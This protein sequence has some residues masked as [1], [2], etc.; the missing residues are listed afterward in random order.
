VPV[1]IEAGPEVIAP[2]EAEAGEEVEGLP[3]HGRDAVDDR[4]GIGLRVLQRAV[5][6]VD[7]RQPALGDLGLRSFPGL[8]HLPGAPLAHVVEL[9][10]RAQPL[11]LELGD[12]GGRPGGRAVVPGSGELVDRLGLDRLGVD[13]LGAGRLGIGRL[14]V[15]ELVRALAALTHGW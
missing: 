3:A 9:G 10:Q 15:D 7:H 14:G 2:R 11:V 6:V 5:Q 13:R 8:A 12:A 1:R 4:T